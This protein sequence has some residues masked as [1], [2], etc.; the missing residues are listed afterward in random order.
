MGLWNTLGW[1]AQAKD[2]E[3]A[4]WLSNESGNSCILFSTGNR[5]EGFDIYGAGFVS[6]VFVGG[7]VLKGTEQS[8]LG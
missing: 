7:H 4:S 3:S 2:T 5:L 8:I 1:Q 6:W